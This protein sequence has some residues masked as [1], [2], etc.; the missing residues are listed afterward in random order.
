VSTIDIGKAEQQDVASICVIQDK[1]G[2]SVWPR[3]AYEA[4]VSRKDAIFL[5]G[6]IGNSGPVGFITGRVISGGAGH[7]PEA[8]IYNVGVLDEFR[9]LGIGAGLLRQFL[10]ICR[11]L[12]VNKVILEVRE[13]NARAIDFYRA[14]GFERTGERTNFYNGPVENAAI[15]TLRLECGP[16]SGQISKSA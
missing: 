10:N 2:L 15:M 8:E 3:S 13:S 9:R 12:G 14:H 6:K 4:E 7:S 1:C 5:V 16:N 11:G